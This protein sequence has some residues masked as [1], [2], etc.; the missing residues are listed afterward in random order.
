MRPIRPLFATRRGR[1]T[2]RRTSPVLAAVG[3]AT[4]LSLTATACGSGDTTANAD[5]SASAQDSG[6][7]GDGKIQIPDDI[8][9][10]LKEHGI[11]LDKW[12]GG[13][14]KNW[15][16][17]DWLREAEDYVNPIIEDLW[18]P[19]RMRD[20][21]EPEKEVDES[22]LTGDQGVTDPTPQS[23]DAEAVSTEYHANAPEAG[24]V[25][26]D[27]P[28]GTMVCSATVVQDPANP[29]K[30][31]LV[32]TAGH[33]VHAGKSGGWYR[34]IAF[35]PSYNDSGMS[36]SELQTAT[37]EQ[38]APYGVWWG[39]WAQ[40]SDQW[41]EQGGQSGGDGAPYDFAVIHVTPEEGSG[42]KSLEEMVG[43][44]LPVDFDAPAVP[45]VE[46]ITA[47]GYPAGAPYDG[48][49]MY[50]CTDKPGRLSLVEADPTMYRIGCSMTGGSSGGGWVATGSDGQP[51]LVSNTSIGPVSAGWL[52]GPRLGKDAEGVYQAVSDKFAQ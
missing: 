43:S 11:D 26:F 40:T 36:A 7:A 15:D 51:A 14:W 8:K 52:A 3:L 47:T 48:E 2:R 33:C 50:Q 28:E 17:D 6:S 19:D 4:V 22:D 37:K 5:A 39:D 44:A 42:G 21:E 16:K 38:V 23:V 46:S 41:I 27:A 25:F 18:D 30:S 45:Q 34:N 20:A 32:W 13:A 31:N 35:V 49:T 10:K 9:D 29:G 1:S 12:R 24:K